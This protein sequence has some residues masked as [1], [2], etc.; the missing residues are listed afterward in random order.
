MFKRTNRHTHIYFQ[1]QKATWIEKKVFNFI[2]DQESQAWPHVAHR[3]CLCDPCHHQTSSNFTLTQCF[4]TFFGSRHPY[5]V[6]KIFS[7]TPRCLNRYKDKGIVIIGGTLAPAHDTPLALT[8]NCGP[9]KSV[10]SRESF[11]LQNAAL[12]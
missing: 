12:I 3:M 6:M 1:V 7:G 2:T 5:L 11:F 10:F 8:F 4:P 9:R